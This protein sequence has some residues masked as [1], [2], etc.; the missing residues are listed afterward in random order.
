MR[1]NSLWHFT[2]SSV[3]D[4]SVNAH[5]LL[6]R[7]SYFL[8]ILWWWSLHI[9]CDILCDLFKPYAYVFLCKKE[10]FWRTSSTKNLF[11][12]YVHL[13]KAD[14]CVQTIFFNRSLSPT[15]CHVRKK[16]MR[17][18]KYF[19]LKTIECLDGGGNKPKTPSHGDHTQK[20]CMHHVFIYL[21]YI[22]FTCTKKSQIVKGR[23]ET[24]Q[25]I[26]CGGLLR[27]YKFFNKGKFARRHTRKNQSNR[28]IQ[29]VYFL[30]CSFFIVLQGIRS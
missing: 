21:L 2:S 29:Q 28:K 27:K 20:I 19:C 4:D 3:P 16:E 6:S 17:E 11:H 26:L 1:K 25:N 22:V 13:L 24:S 7:S 10:T 9:V 15:R 5:Y 12:A 18:K 23:Q 14:A 30:L 8:F